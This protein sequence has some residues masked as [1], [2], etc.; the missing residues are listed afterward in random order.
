[1]FINNASWK[2]FIPL[3]IQ[4]FASIKLLIGAIIN[5]I[6]NFILIP[7]LGLQGAAISTVITILFV[8]IFG[9]LFFTKTKRNFT[10][11]L[12]SI[13]TIYRVQQK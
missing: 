12:K 13:Q 9:N 4:K 2:Y 7:F 11:I 8:A 6:L 5:I 1:M 10:L 3:N